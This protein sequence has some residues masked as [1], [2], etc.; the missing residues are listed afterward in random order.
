MS[1]ASSR[2]TACQCQLLRLAGLGCRTT[3]WPAPRPSVSTCLDTARMEHSRSGLLLAPPP[4]ALPLCV[5]RFRAPRAC[6]YLAKT[7]APSDPTR[8]GHAVDDLRRSCDQDSDARRSGRDFGTPTLPP[9][10]Q[11]GSGAS[12]GWGAAGHFDPARR[13]AA[14][15]P[16]EIPRYP[17]SGRSRSSHTHAKPAGRILLPRASA[18]GR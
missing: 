11:P 18:S 5:H 12:H 7:G 10:R 14:T 15:S 16:A 6:A 2:R 9:G 1:D 17:G 13:A 3:R 8:G 4:P